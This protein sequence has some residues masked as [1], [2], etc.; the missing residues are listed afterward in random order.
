MLRKQ[1]TIFAITTLASCFALVAGINLGIVALILPLVYTAVFAV[2]TVHLSPYLTAVT[3]TLNITLALAFSK[4]LFTTF[5]MVP[6]MIL[7][8]ILI[9]VTVIKKYNN[10]LSI[11]WGILATGG[12]YAAYIL[13]S[14]KILGINPVTDMFYIMEQTLSDVSLQ[15]GMQ[16]LSF[17][18]EYINMSRNVFIAVMII[19]FSIIGFIVAYVASLALR[20]F[21]SEKQLSLSFD[22]FKADSVTVFI[23]IVSL[24]CAIFVSN[25][26]LSVVFMDLYL[27][28]QFYL[29]ICGVSI[30]Y[31]ILKKRLRVPSVVTKIIGIALLFLS[32]VG[33]FSSILVLLAI[34]DA[35]RNF[36]NLQI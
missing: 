9:G 11:I 15:M 25:D 5:V 32:M 36:R 3:A 10:K 35:K 16:D 2:E 22:D 17:A 12:V 34:V 23:Y 31:Y 28:L 8:G 29:T 7:A 21:K 30:I 13:Y 14:I 6:F 18:S 24:I 27:V 20:I 26:M 33:I 19:V 4:D 1:T